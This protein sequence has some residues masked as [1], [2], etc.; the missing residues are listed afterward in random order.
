MVVTGAL[1]LLFPSQEL[2]KS[3]QLIPDSLNN[4]PL[5]NESETPVMPKPNNS[6]KS[7]NCSKTQI[8]DEQLDFLKSKIKSKNA[9]FPMILD[10]HKNELGQPN[11]FSNKRENNTGNTND[12]HEYKFQTPW[13]SSKIK[14]ADTNKDFPSFEIL[15]EDIKENDRDLNKNDPIGNTSDLSQK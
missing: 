5:L 12:S 11:P 8:L 7:P 10:D 1:E 13:K 15:Q 2:S 9:I 4:Y 3:V 6:T 14:K